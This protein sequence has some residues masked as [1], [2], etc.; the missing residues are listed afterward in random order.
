MLML[1]GQVRALVGSGSVAK[2]VALPVK[3]AFTNLVSADFNRAG[4]AVQPRLM[5]NDHSSYNGR[6]AF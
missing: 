2:C 6:I 1:M 3:R 5:K 4:A